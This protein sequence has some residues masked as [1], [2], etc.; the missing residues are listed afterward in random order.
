MPSR[1]DAEALDGDDPLA[2]YRDRFVIDNVGDTNVIYADGNSLGRLPKAARDALHHAIDTEWGKGLIGSWDRWIDLPQRTGD[3][4]GTAILGAREGQTIVADSTTVNFYKLAVAALRARPDGA[5]LTDEANFPTNRF[6]LQGLDRAIHLLPPDPTVDDVRAGIAAANGPVALVTLSHVAYRSGARLDIE[7]ITR[8]AHDAGA[9]VLWDLSHSAG[10]IAVDLADTGA[11]MAVGCT[12]K[13]LNAGPGAPA[14]L[15]VR[16]DLHDELRQPIQGWF[17][18]LDQFAMAP[19]YEPASGIAR[20]MS[21]TPT[22]LA[23]TAVEAG[24]RITA[25]AGIHPIAAKAAALTDF[26][27]AAADDALAPLGFDVATPREPN[28]RGAHVALRHDDAWRICRVLVERFGVVVDFREP[29][30]VRVGLAPLYSRYVDAWDAIDRTR[31]A[32]AQGAHHDMPEE[33]RR[34]T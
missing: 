10:A 34:I 30:I 24:A 20:F 22:V 8:A 5:V 4:I 12:Y 6:V 33:R 3:L 7:G 16:A 18:A 26:V 23:L 32:V 28:E 11:D 1:A 13:Y 9:L 17:G 19:S 21:G 2:P 14:F 27:I 25:E 29:D 15:Y 31:E